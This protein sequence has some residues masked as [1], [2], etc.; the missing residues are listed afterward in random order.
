MRAGY[1][2]RTAPQQ[3]ARMLMNVNIKSEIE[4]RLNVQTALFCWRFILPAIN[5][6]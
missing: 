5:R 3:A 2:E 1:S 4:S 6:R